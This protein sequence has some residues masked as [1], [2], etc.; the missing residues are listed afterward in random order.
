MNKQTDT[1][2]QIGRL[3]SY[4][5][6]D[7]H[8]VAD[9]LHSTLRTDVPDAA[10]SLAVF[11]DHIRPMSISDLEE[12]FTRTFDINPA[13]ALEIGWHLFGEEYA[14]GMFLVR[15]RAE[16]RRRGLEESAE[17][18]DHIAHV[19][20]VLSA[21]PRDE[22]SEFLRACVLPA[23]VKMR[24]ALEEKQNAYMSVINALLHVFIHEFEIAGTFDE[25][26]DNAEH[27][28]TTVGPGG[29]PLQDFPVQVSGDGQPE[30]VPLHMD[31]RDAVGAVMS[32][33]GSSNGTGVPPEH[34]EGRMW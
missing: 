22:A 2:T 3:L 15:M 25:M 19:L 9:S 5:L 13:C 20:G 27:A 30:I 4:P 10:N 7:Y 26:I 11:R 21:M 24:R 6:D 16:M 14:R 34:D 32:V 29:D 23:V 28:E 12:M 1:L 31:Y 17:L 8:D 33:N 18:P